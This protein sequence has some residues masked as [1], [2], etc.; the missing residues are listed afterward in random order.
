MLFASQ[1]G[2]YFCYHHKPAYFEPVCCIEHILYAEQQILGT[3]CDK[4]DLLDT[5]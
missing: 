5:P 1:I 3:Q 2:W 4:S